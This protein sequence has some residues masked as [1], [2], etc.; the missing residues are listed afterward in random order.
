[1]IDRAETPTKS[2]ISTPVNQ[3]PW[4]R[5]ERWWVIGVMM[6]GLLHGLI[7]LFMMPPWQHYEEPSHFEYIWLISTRLAL[8]KYP[9]YDQE[10]RRVIAS[11]MIEHG[12]FHNLR[13]LP[14]LESQDEP[15]WIG[16][17]VTGALP[18]YHM[19]AAVPLR[20]F[21]NTKVETQLYVLRFFSLCLYISTIFIAY[22]I[23]CEFVTHG[24]TLRWMVP[25]SMALVP[26]FA[27]LMTS[28]NNDVGATFMFSIFLFASVRIILRGFSLS[29]LF[30][31]S[32]IAILCFFTKNTVIIAIPLGILA[33]VLSLSKPRTIVFLTTISG[34]FIIAVL[35]SVFSWGDAAYW[36]R[37]SP[38]DQPN[39]TE[40]R[41]APLGRY[42]FHTIFD[43]ET[44]KN[45]QFSQTLTSAE[46]NSLKGHIITVGA[47]I[48]STKK[49]EAYLPV[50]TDGVGVYEQSI[51]IDKKPTWYSFIV[52]INENA[53]QIQVHLRSPVLQNNS[54]KIDVYYDGIVLLPGD[55]SQFI[56]PVF[57]DNQAN[58]FTWNNEIRKNYIRNGS[59]EK[60]WPWVR[61]QFERLVQKY[62]WLAHLSPS[63]YVSAFF[64][65]ERTGWIYRISAVRIFQTFWGRFGWAHIPL[66]QIWYWIL[67]LVT[68]LAGIANLFS[69]KRIISNHLSSWNVAI[70]W[71]NLSMIVLWGI[72]L[73]RG[74]FTANQDHVFIP[75]ARYGFPVMIPTILILSAGWYIMLKHL[76][77]LKTPLFFVLFI[78]LDFSSILTVVHYYSGIL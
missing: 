35:V 40:S 51:A 15:I 28:V 44:P 54:G 66:S 42:I 68:I 11:S 32:C 48:W 38:Q 20:F 64:D 18:L 6:I 31:L 63:I 7:Y 1:M 5:T 49:I 70:L 47:W 34:I 65:W 52:T 56:A 12:F 33:I 29:R 25:G 43:G 69:L 67:F 24:N 46:F 9:A 61:P 45:F 2:S 76:R 4:Y 14:D 53:S 60:P 10:E 77:T 73:T 71:L 3:P 19:L 22:K 8:P 59:A 26:G 30:G 50:V 36:Y 62:P 58:S 75:S 13:F 37:N 21:L 17:N 72:V 74:L 23:T 39:R 57:L 16:V 41:S 78:V 27:D 55:F